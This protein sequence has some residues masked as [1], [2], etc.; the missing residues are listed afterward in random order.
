MR[1]GGKLTLCTLANAVG[2]PAVAVPADRTDDGLP[3]GVQLIGGRG[4]NLEVIA[5]ARALEEA[6]GGF[7]AP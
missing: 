5:A 3:I 7:I 2:L 6:C 1:P 4:R